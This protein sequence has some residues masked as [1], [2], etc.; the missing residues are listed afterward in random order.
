MNKDDQSFRNLSLSFRG[1]ERQ[2]PSVLQIALRF[3]KIMERQSGSMSGNTEARLKRVVASF[4][5]S[6]GL[7]VKH[8][9]D[10]DKERTVLNLIVGT[11]KDH[12]CQTKCCNNLG[13]VFTKCALFSKSCFHVI[14]FG[15]C[16]FSITLF[17]EAREK[18]MQHLSFTK[19]RDSAFSTEQLR[20]VRWL[21]GAKPKGLP[22]SLA[23]IL[24]MSAQAQSML[25]ELHIRS[26]TEAT[27]RL[28]VSAWSRK[29]AS[30]E[31]FDKMVDFAC[32]FSH[33]RIEA[34]RVNS[35]ASVDSKLVSAF[36]AKRSALNKR[37][38]VFFCEL[39]GGYV[40]SFAASLF[41]ADFNHHHL[42]DYFQEIEAAVAFKSPQFRVE[43]LSIWMDIVSPPAVPSS[44]QQ[45]S[46]ADVLAAQEQASASRFNEVKVRL[47]S[48]CQ[49]MN[50]FNVE[51][52]KVAGKQHVAK[53]MHEKT[54]LAAGKTTLET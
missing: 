32:M 20:T 49:A 41:F 48:D 39:A 44:L 10:A 42:R 33:L 19:W 6:P 11:C 13:Y 25:V 30:A 16:L 28:K 53:V 3:S 40:C 29:R 5:A 36:L 37:N 27:R 51:K 21:L 52:N 54:Q 50:Q 2:A 9:L 43:S 38:F 12:G 8:Q 15:F 23:D 26:F 7:H 31:D 46:G 22:D 1:A 18:M 4:N 24:T 47:A 14:T 35:D 17:Q 34:K 45:E